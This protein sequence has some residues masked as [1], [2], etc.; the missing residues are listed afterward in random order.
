MLI[1]N[2]FEVDSSI[3]PLKDYSMQRGEKK[4]GLN[5]SNSAHLPHL[6]KNSFNDY[7]IEIP[8]SVYSPVNLLTKHFLKKNGF[9][10]K[11]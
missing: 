9:G 3:Y 10:K 4:G 1:K 8:V 6:W 2:K 11:K 7:L 5:F